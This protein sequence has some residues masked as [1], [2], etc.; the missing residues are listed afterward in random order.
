L[1]HSGF[2]IRGNSNRG[3]PLFAADA[4]FCAHAGRFG[5]GNVSLESYNTRASPYRALCGGGVD[6]AQRRIPRLGNPA[7]HNGHVS[8]QLTSPWAP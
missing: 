2:R 1:R 7:G 5:G 3:S 4:T 8:W 6:R